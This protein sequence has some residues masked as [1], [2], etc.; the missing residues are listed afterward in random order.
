MPRTFNA[1]TA[2]LGG[3][4]LMGMFMPFVRGRAAVAATCCGILT[5]VFIGYYGQIGWVLHKL[6]VIANL[7]PTLSPNWVMPCA[8]TVTLTSAALFSLFDRSPAK[9]LAA[10]TWYTRREKSPLTELD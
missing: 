4:F 9:N 10:L 2:P 3:L 5:S 8:I 6:G 1:I 7:T